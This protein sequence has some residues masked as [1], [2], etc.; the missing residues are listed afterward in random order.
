[1]RLS[2]SSLL[3]WSVFAASVSAEPAQYAY[4]GTVRTVGPFPF[5]GLSV[6][7]GDPVFGRFRYQ[8]DAVDVRPHPSL[9]EHVQM[10]PSFV[11]VKVGGIRFSSEGGF[12]SVV[13]NDHVQDPFNPDDLPSDY[14]WLTDG[15]PI[16]NDPIRANGI[17]Q[18]GNLRIQF[19]DDTANIWN[20]D[21]LPA[22]IH[23][24]DFT[25]TY[26]QVFLQ[27]SNSTHLITFGI[28]T[29]SSIPEPATCA[30]SSIAVVASVAC[31]HRRTPANY[32]LG[33]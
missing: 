1:M 19:V 31:R 18:H 5:P 11:E 24:G 7:P 30:L 28:D 22:A 15:D 12:T 16:A 26:G 10:P 33:T 4:T 14:F 25:R 27:T 32:T 23:L 9:S 13:L 20:G 17:S 3:V 2:L 6:Q 8:P 21:S 29:L